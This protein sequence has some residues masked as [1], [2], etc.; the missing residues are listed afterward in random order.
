MLL[1]QKQKKYDL[2][3]SNIAN[4]GTDLEKKTRE[5]A[6]HTEE[7]W[8]VAGKKVGIQVWRAV[9]FSVEDWPEKQH[10]QFFEGDSYIILHTHKKSPASESF[11]WDLYY[12]LGKRTT[13]DEAGTAAYKTVELDDH[14]GGA[15]IEHREIQEH[16]SNEFLKLFDGKVRYLS[17]GADSGFHHV[18]PES[19]RPRLLQVRGSKENVSAKE[20][21]LSKDSLNSGDVFI[22]DLGLNV[23][24]WCGKSAGIFEK[25]KASQI[26]RA[27]DDER[28]GQVQIKVVLEGE[29]SD[30]SAAFWKVFGGEGAVKSASQGDKEATGDKVS[31]QK[32]LFQV[33][34]ANFTEVSP[35]SK[36][37]LKSDDV[38]ILDA[39]C[40]IFVWV[41]KGSSKQE[42]T[43]SI[44]HAQ[45][46]L[47]K[48]G[49]PLW[50]PITRIMEGGENEV[51]FHHLH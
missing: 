42:R 38:F 19:Y 31:G 39:V 9:K 49:R 20:R 35:V 13:Q 11:V 26:V 18:A 30:D 50:V 25:N 37:T 23:Y 46:Y 32:R 6:A 44:G 17:G 34:D 41:G 21:N 43:S 36:N 1:K 3:G 10:G 12:W 16:E 28:K 45:S 7:K 24:Q 47:Q 27:F 33:K 22:L 8:K 48:N 40:E 15:P 5:T 51:F 14:L 2:S 29:S 4:L